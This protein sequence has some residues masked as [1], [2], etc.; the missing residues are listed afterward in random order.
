MGGP[1]YTSANQ[2]VA[3]IQ[4][5]QTGPACYD[6]LMSE[7]DRPLTHGGLV[8]SAA[9]AGNSATGS[10]LDG[11]AQDD[12]LL[13]EARKLIEDLKADRHV[14]SWTITG[15]LKKL[16]ARQDAPAQALLADLRSQA[17][18]TLTGSTDVRF[19]KEFVEPFY[20]GTDDPEGYSFYSEAII[21]H[22][23]AVEPIAEVMGDPA[24]DQLVDDLDIL[25]DFCVAEKVYGQKALD[26]SSAIRQLQAMLDAGQKMD[27]D[28]FHAVDL[29]MPDIRKHMF[30]PFVQEAVLKDSKRFGRVREGVDSYVALEAR[31][32]A[33]PEGQYASLGRFEPKAAID[34]RGAGATP[35]Y[36]PISEDQGRR[37]VDLAMEQ[38]QKMLDG[39]IEHL[40]PGDIH[41]LMVRLRMLKPHAHSWNQDRVDRMLSSL[42]RLYIATPDS[43][44]AQEPG[45]DGAKLQF[46]FSQPFGVSKLKGVLNTIANEPGESGELSF[47]FSAEGRFGNNPI[48]RGYVGGWVSLVLGY[49][50][51]DTMTCTMAFDASAAVRAGI[52]FAGIAKAGVTGGAGYNIAARFPNPDDAAAWLFQTFEKVNEETQD[53]AGMRIFETTGGTAGPS[54]SP[55]IVEEGR[56]FGGGEASLDLPAVD[57]NTSYIGTYAQAGFT[58]D[59]STVQENGV[60]VTR[61]VTREQFTL[62][63]VV[64]TP[65]G[66]DLKG[67][68]TFTG[69]KIQG[70]MNTANDGTYH[71]HK[72]DIGFSLDTLI[73][74]LSNH[75]KQDVVPADKLQDGILETFARW[76]SR[77]P[78]GLPRQA[79]Q[80]VFDQVVTQVYTA[81]DLGRQ[82]KAGVDVSFG[83]EWHQEKKRDSYALQYFRFGVTPTISGKLEFDTAVLE[84]EGELAARKTEVLYES[85]GS[86]TYSYALQRYAFA[87]DDQQWDDFAAANEADLSQMMANMMDPAHQIY[88]KSFADDAKAAGYPG[89]GFATG[90]QALERFFETQRAGLTRGES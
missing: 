27:T 46:D 68:Y 22:A 86:D 49:G 18:E 14:F 21:R 12:P 31:M 1:S 8:C 35:T 26:M 53:N 3:P 83:F 42:D 63:A 61:T 29:W 4:S 41:A 23:V 64:P 70:D 56:A 78:G 71:N 54:V 50:V 72:V 5:Q 51:T 66:P 45:E 16:Q 89:A 2:S 34:A 52:D 39:E 10:L 17:A 38:G 57:A 58:Q 67:A 20:K 84:T 81:M 32:K 48:V 69:E 82:V 19:A 77:M 85:I 9:L 24:L 90:L 6:P 43:E 40:T 28:L 65:M 74:K 44:L 59:G 15:M 55:V 62:G 47:S 73:K 7:Q 79:L 33:D 87:W 37:D 88:E 76:E 80:G 11:E 25:R 13:E 36:T 30:N 60:D 75:R